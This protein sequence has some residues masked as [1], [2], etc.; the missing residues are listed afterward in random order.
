MSRIPVVV[1]PSV[2]PLEAIQWLFADIFDLRL[3]EE[4]KN[5]NVQ[6]SKQVRILRIDSLVAQEWQTR[7]SEYRSILVNPED[8]PKKVTEDLRNEV[9]I[10]DFDQ[11]LFDSFAEVLAVLQMSKHGASDFKAQLRSNVPNVRVPDF[12]CTIRGDD[13]ALEVKNLR[14]YRYIENEVLELFEDAKLKNI[15]DP[16]RALVALR[17]DH[18]L[19]EDQEI[20]ELRRLVQSSSG[21]PFDTD[22]NVSLSTTR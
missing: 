9:K 13:A 5:R 17:S 10:A 20:D 12:V 3:A 4:S 16:E 8:A 7:I 6:W 2:E 19:L 18:G 21:C 15:V 11:K 22:Q 1:L 14:S